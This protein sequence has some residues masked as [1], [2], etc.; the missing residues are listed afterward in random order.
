MLVDERQGKSKKKSKK[1]SSSTSELEYVGS[2]DESE[3]EYEADSEQTISQ[4]TIQVE[5]IR[6]R[7][8]DPTSKRQPLARKAISDDGH[9]IAQVMSLSEKKRKGLEEEG[10]KNKRPK[11]AI[12]VP[13]VD[14]T[15]ASLGD[16]ESNA[17]SGIYLLRMMKKPS[18]NHFHNNHLC[19][20]RNHHIIN[21]H[22]NK[23][24]INH[25]NNNRN[26]SIFPQALRGSLNQH[27]TGCWFLKPNRI[28]NIHQVKGS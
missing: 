4:I 27:Q 19:K 18:N 6:P 28:C 1:E 11:K 8:N 26:S 20:K 2:S 24:N 10:S 16:N 9:T 23:K 13:P 3:F 12:E 15:I 25:L 14:S 17:G 7:R 21:H 5:R 22:H